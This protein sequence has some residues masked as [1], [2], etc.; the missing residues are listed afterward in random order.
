MKF[1]L[2]NLRFSF[3]FVNMLHFFIFVNIRIIRKHNL[4]LDVFL[5][6]FDDR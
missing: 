5:I 2:R 1:D 6:N 3:Y 4:E